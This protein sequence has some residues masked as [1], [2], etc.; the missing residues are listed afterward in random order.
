MSNKTIQIIKAVRANENY[1]LYRLLLCNYGHMNLTN[2]S[3]VVMRTKLFL[4]I[5]R[6]HQ[7]NSKTD[8]KYTSIMDYVST[9]IDKIVCPRV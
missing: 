4:S 1:H 6:M 3:I 8:N 7:Y 2:I 5:K 9:I